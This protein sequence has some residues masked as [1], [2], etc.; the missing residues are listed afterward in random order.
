TDLADLLVQFSEYKIPINGG[1]HDI[2]TSLYLED[3]EGNGLEFY[4]DNPIDE[5]SI[6]NEKAVLETKPLNVPKLLT[7]VSDKKWQGIPDESIIGYIN[8]KTIRLNRVKQYYKNYFGLVPSSIE[9]DRD[10]KSTR[11]NSSHVSIS[12]A[13]FCLKKKII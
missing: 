13:V 1:E 2:S 9:T 12:Y 8:L 11:L 4:V 5:W 3:T 7:Y 10:R 6:E